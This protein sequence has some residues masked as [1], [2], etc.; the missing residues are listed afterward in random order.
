MKD[1]KNM[2]ALEV[3]KY[4]LFIAKLQDAG[5][6]ISNLKIQKLLYYA[7]GESL[8]NRGKKLFDEEIEAWDHGPVVPKVYYAYKKYEKLA[9]DFKE[10]TEFDTKLFYEEDLE[11]IRFCYQKY[12]CMGAWQLRNATHAEDPW[13]NNY[14]RFE[15]AI[16][17]RNDM[18]RYF[19]ERN[20]AELNSALAYM[21]APENKDLFA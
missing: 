15:N 12:A 14:V 13:R 10:I 7:Q 1:K 17:P 8:L 5:D 2:K 11:L 20:E 18:Q 19:K 3:A 21:N 6:T 4:F 9:I 16:I